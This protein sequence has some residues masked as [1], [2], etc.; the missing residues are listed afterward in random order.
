M[1]LDQAAVGFMWNWVLS[2]AI[3]RTGVKHDEHFVKPDEA[4]EVVRNATIESSLIAIRVIDEFFA[5]S[6][7]RSGDIRSHHYAGYSSPG[8]FLEK[9]EYDRIGRSVAHLTVDRADSSQ[10]PWQ[11]VELIRRSYVPSEN[12]LAFIVEGAGTKFLPDPPFDVRSRLRYCRE[13][14]R[15]MQRILRQQKAG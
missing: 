12:F 9:S 6:G 5:T 3:L 2:P 14:D 15:V 11:I 7:E 10:N 8:R 13:M 1:L 4:M